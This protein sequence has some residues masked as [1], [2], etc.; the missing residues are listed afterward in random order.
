MRRITET[1]EFEVSGDQEGRRLDLFLSTAYPELSRSYLKRLIEEGFVRVGGEVVRKPSRRVRR[2]ETVLLS[3]PEPEPV[4]VKPEDIPIEILYEDRDLAVVVKPCGLV[5]HPS[6]GHASG[7]LVNA[8]LFHLRDLSSVGG[9]ERPGIVHRLDR[10]TAGLMVVAKNDT[11][12]RSL[13]EQFARRRT[14]KLYRVIVQGLVERPH[15]T[16][17]LP[18]G[19]HPTARKK[20]T[21]LREGGR[22][23]KSEFWVLERFSSTETTLLR[24]RIYTGRTHQIRVHLSAGGHPVLGDRVYGFRGR[25]LPP[26]LLELMGECN[27]LVAYRLGFFHPGSGEWLTFEIEDPEPFRSVLEKLRELEGTLG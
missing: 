26:D 25:R 7:T 12:H 6:P 21:A 10:E 11:A 18:I 1:L 19:R 24:A 5:V 27:M 20:F 2:G 3:V 4:E 9:R 22:S 8:L 14:E 15:F 23:A 13:V 16:V 17:E